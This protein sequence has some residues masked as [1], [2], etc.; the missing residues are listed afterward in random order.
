MA[1]GM[2]NRI[3]RRHSALLTLMDENQRR[4]DS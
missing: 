1:Q 2:P 3:W 4:K